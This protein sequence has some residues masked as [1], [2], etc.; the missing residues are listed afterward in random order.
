MHD[1]AASYYYLI[2]DFVVAGC[3]PI[4]I[5]SHSMTLVYRDCEFSVEYEDDSAPFITTR[6]MGMT[7]RGEA[8]SEIL[9]YVL[10][11]Q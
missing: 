11:A 5:Q 8:V 2:G 6:G 1:A 4:L 10:E 3:K 9:D 7:Y